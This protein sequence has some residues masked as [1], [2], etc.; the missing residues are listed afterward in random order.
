MVY[1]RV[2]CSNLASNT[3]KKENVSNLNNVT[4]RMWNQSH[5]PFKTTC[6]LYSC[7]IA[8]NF[9]EWLKLFHRISLQKE[10]HQNVYIITKRNRTIEKKKLWAEKPKRPLWQTTWEAHIQQYLPQFELVAHQLTLNLNQWPWLRSKTSFY[11]LHPISSTVKNMTN[12][13]DPLSKNYQKKHT[14]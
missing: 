9:T 6:D 12:L 1:N 13:F 11:F 4:W 7:F 3:I 8:L 10:K 5:F 2:T 14:F